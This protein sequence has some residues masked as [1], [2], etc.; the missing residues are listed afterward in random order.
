MTVMTAIGVA[1]FLAITARFFA[2]AART[3]R[4]VEG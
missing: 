1:A 4:K 3:T 2:H